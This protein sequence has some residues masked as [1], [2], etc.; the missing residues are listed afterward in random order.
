MATADAAA[1]LAEFTKKKAD[2]EKA[3]AEEQKALAEEEKKLIDAAR[4]Q[5]EVLRLLLA[6]HGNQGST[7]S[8]PAGA[9][10]TPSFNGGAG[11][12]TGSAWSQIGAP[13]VG[14][15]VWPEQQ[16]DP[17]RA[18]LTDTIPDPNT[19]R[20]DSYLEDFKKMQ[21]PTCTV[22]VNGKVCIVTVCF[23]RVYV[24][25]EDMWKRMNLRPDKMDTPNGFVYTFTMSTET[26][27]KY[28]GETEQEIKNAFLAH[29]ALDFSRTAKNGNK[30]TYSVTAEFMAHHAPKL[31][32]SDNER[33]YLTSDEMFDGTA[34]FMA[35]FLSN[36]GSG[37]G[38]KVNNYAPTKIN[39]THNS[40]GGG[41]GGTNNTRSFKPKVE[42]KPE[43]EFTPKHGR[44]LTT[45]L[46]NCRNPIV[47]VNPKDT[48]GYKKVRA[49]LEAYE[50]GF[51]LTT[52]TFSSP[53]LTSEEI[54]KI[55]CG[56]FGLKTEAELAEAA[57][58]VKSAEFAAAAQ[59][60]PNGAVT[61]QGAFG[62]L[63][64]AADAADAAGGDAD[65]ADTADAAGGDADTDEE[66]TEYV[67][68]PYIAEMFNSVCEDKR[69]EICAVI[70]GKFS[71]TF[72]GDK[73]EATD[74]REITNCKEIA[75]MVMVMAFEMMSS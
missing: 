20:F 42:G 69:K 25:A 54:E 53:K 74:G 71:I 64:D 13:A 67:L 66:T 1:A 63:A 17:V 59:M 4:K 27:A 35:D 29:L 43:N 39:I 65:A 18:A 62:P 34:R 5:H 72:D 19:A 6:A 38:A 32:L 12:V 31:T 28:Y 57:R 49:A 14:P 26:A 22:K 48:E 3:H 44:L 11:R 45:H 68:P 52:N 7:G 9:A 75:K 60:K 50:I 30:Q 56:I 37:G 73:Y 55:L 8:V 47:G 61:N 41:G 24:H 15:L 21:V 40:G 2:A 36:R 33:G 70:G 51:N 58:K 10:T 46:A 23:G 16:T